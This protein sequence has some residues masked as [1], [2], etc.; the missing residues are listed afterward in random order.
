MLRRAIAT[1]LEQRY[2]GRLQVTIV[3]DGTQPDRSLDAANIRTIVNVRAPGLAGARNSGILALDTDLVAFC[4]DDDEWLPG[5]LEA[6]LGA[7]AATG[8]EFATA[9]VIITYGAQT[10]VRLAGKQL[11]THADLLRSRILA[12]PASGFLIRR[13]ALLDGLGLVD[14]SIPGSQAEDWDLLLRASARRPIAHVDEPLV[15]TPWHVGSY[16][17]KRWDTK[18]AALTWMLARH[19]GITRDARAAARVYGQIAFAHAALGSRRRAV[20]WS[21]KALARRPAEPRAYI[22]LGVAGGLLPA[23]TVLAFLHRRARGI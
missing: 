10:R 22:A 6:Q 7:L 18:A 20:R 3:Y 23:E 5:K 2:P 8:A 15:R 19:P 16:F 1:V 12:L 11:V 4:D 13:P 17:A 9:A 21:L 14:E